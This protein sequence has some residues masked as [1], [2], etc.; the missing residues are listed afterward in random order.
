MIRTQQQKKTVF[1]NSG[2]MTRR[3][4]SSSSNSNNNNRSKRKRRF[5]FPAASCFHWSV[6]SS[7]AFLLM[8][9]PS[10][11]LAIAPKY[12]TAYACEGKTLMIECENGDLINLIRANYGR[13]S[14]TICN[15]H[16][17]VDWS[18]N[19]MSPKSL[20]VLHSKCA[21]KQN[22]SVLASTNMFGD[23][24]PGTHKYLEAHYQC[25]SAAQSSTTTN[26]PSPPWLKTSQPIV[27]STSTV[28]NPVLSKLNFS[29]PLA[30]FGVTSSA[31]TSSGITTGVKVKPTTPYKQQ[32]L[33][34]NNQQS[35]P[36]FR[37]K[38]FDNKSVNDDLAIIKQIS[39]AAGSGGKKIAGAA[40]EDDEDFGDDEDYY[41]TQT[42]VLSNANRE[43][44]GSSKG[45]GE[46]NV[47][48]GGSPSS[49]KNDNHDSP[50][51]SSGNSN[52]GSNSNSNSNSISGGT[53]GSDSGNA[54]NNV[55][56]VSHACGP[57]TARS[58]F[59]N[60]TRVGEAN[61]QPCP[62]GAT[63]IAKWRCVAIG[64]LTPEQRLQLQ[65]EQQQQQSFL[66]D[67]NKSDISFNSNLSGN[68][69]GGAVATW[70]SYQPDLTQC[71]SLWLNSL[72]VRV[73]QQQ[74]S[75]LI[76]IANDL[77]QVTSSKTLY[78]GDMLV[79]TKIIQTM[80]QKMHFDIETIPDQRQK[81]TLVYELLN[82]VVKTGSNL[83]DQSQHA[84]WLDLSVE[85][86]MR[87]ATSLLTGLEDNAFLLADT[88]LRERHVVQKVKNILLS[89]RV[90]ETRNFV[91]N[92]VFP[93]SSQ[94]RWH[95]SDDLIE[96]PKAALIEN[97]EGGLVRIVF[98]AFD[99]LEQILRPQFSNV[100]QSRVDQNKLEQDDT[101]S[102]PAA[103]AKS[104]VSTAPR[105]RLLNSKVISAS[106]GKGRHI[107][108]S[109][110]IRMVLKHL[111]TKNVSN[112]A[113]V[114]WN[115]IDHAWSEDGCYVEYTN[116][117]HTIC[118]CNH[119]TNFALL[120]DAIDE[121][122][123]S[124]LSIIDDDIKILIYISVAIFVVI[125]VVALFSL[126]LFNGVFAKVRNGSRRHH[127][128]S[129]ANNNAADLHLPNHLQH[130]GLI[131]TGQHHHLGVGG[132]ADHLD[133][134]IHQHQLPH[135][136]Q[137]Q[138]QQYSSG[139]MTTDS[140]HLMRPSHHHNH[141]NNNNLVTT[142]FNNLAPGAGGPPGVGPLGVGY[143]TATHHRLAVQ[144]RLNN[145]QISSRSKLLLLPYKPHHQHL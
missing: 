9:L 125:V 20:R 49:K 41:P 22:C 132:G 27:W 142:T 98:V 77:S 45:Y 66:D 141:H 42:A 85:D 53:G 93:D 114:F 19:C 61:V 123:L 104:D 58:L 88:I 89:I 47:P 16:G 65:H 121:T 17:N 32:T 100:H 122:Q 34:V 48:I 95:V 128:A 44:G 74:D 73:N 145:N 43:S 40:P 139:L 115:Y 68:R 4:S 50:S 3:N 140:G 72:E 39:D 109:Q 30:G 57:T 86:Q 110:P 38:G 54:V 101:G 97:S 63:G 26:R 15:D 87:V 134:S 118:M 25:V 143:E 102:N 13:F 64:S 7:V 131:G 116:A 107:Q 62:G 83:L 11:N 28:R 76:S 113:C 91:K 70:Y 35:S 106:L 79:A 60:V 136:Q 135:Q 29:D 71:R 75:S 111:R 92:E 51:S 21:Q 144:E 1:S 46:S 117:T 90:L 127:Q 12:E 129:T 119:L 59:W 99:R 10:L 31:V 56:D 133:V 130:H 37:Q 8:T 105:Q 124:L 126:K 14:I 5:R 24:C 23:P 36:S 6:W 18:V 78:G 108:L 112:P 120:I 67:N 138:Q 84:S 80:S 81:E 94:E 33:M 2:R 69:N 55:L 137:Q 96:L 82:S 103:G 52:S